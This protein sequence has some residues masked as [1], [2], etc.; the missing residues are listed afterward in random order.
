MLV[1]ILLSR[2]LGLVRDILIAHNFGQSGV[3]SAYVS[4]FNLPDLLY[5]FLS[6]GALSSAF[7]PVF[8]EYFNTGREK[9]AW[10]VFSIIGCLMGL[11][12]TSAIVLSW[13]F[14]KPLVG[15]VVPGFAKQHPDLL[16]LTI[17]LT[18]VILP[19]QLF[20]FL[21]GLMM[22]T[23]E[24]RQDFRAR[25]AG[26]VL[27]NLGIIVGVVA[28]SRWIGIHGLAVGA[29]VG[30]FSGSVGYTFYRLRKAGFKFYPSLNFR[31]PGV[32]KVAM[33]AL[34]V[35][36]G[37]T[38]PQIDIVINRMFASGIA[39]DKA[40]AALNNANRLMQ[41]PIGIFAQAAG[42]AILPTLSAQHAAGRIDQMRGSIGFGLR[43]ILI[44]NIPASVFMV[45]M[46]APIVRTVYM[47]GQFHP[48]DVGIC[49][50]AFVWYSVGVFAWAGQAIV[51]RG[52]FAMQDTRT[53]VVLGTIS[54][55]IFIPLNWILLKYMGL[56]GLALATSIAA[57]IHFFGLTWLLRNRLERMELGRVAV[58]AFKV[59]IAAVVLGLVCHGVRIGVERRYERI[60]YAPFAAS[61]IRDP[62]LLV[63]RIIRPEDRLAEYVQSV[64][65][66]STL[67]LMAQAD[68][69]QNTLRSP[70]FKA[71]LVQALN[72]ILDDRGLYTPERFKDAEL[73]GRTLK[74]LGSYPDV[75]NLRLVNRRLLE[76]GFQDEIGTVATGRM[77]SMIVVL[78]SLL[79]GGLAYIVMLR[80]LKEEEASEIWRSIR[81]KVFKR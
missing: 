40:I 34:P 1:A 5:F 49:S 63:E 27:Y 3:V 17:S 55:A 62:K 64:T 67:D 7:I 44:E 25:A 19:C 15:V 53:P 24:S 80:L 47:S 14:A 77:A 20:F 22:G 71:A 56:N 50:S 81:R 57:V 69:S 32:I 33:L 30:S 11:V 48:S 51:A 9:E 59:C 10:Q 31:H 38:L 16:P 68:K 76:E 60:Q 66:K 21:G 46:A 41:V 37:L 18:R 26:P 45:I 6:S 58:T 75:A 2:I 61:Q 78:M 43:T 79:A 52:F 42:T 28:L 36:L 65:S 72:P 70:G 12:L 54:T 29:L 35:I 4:A 8:T 74:M 23:L 13:I 39:T 73:S